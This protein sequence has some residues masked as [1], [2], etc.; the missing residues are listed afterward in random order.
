M[1]LMKIEYS[2]S[3]IN[4]YNQCLLD[5]IGIYI[6]KVIIQTWYILGDFLK[7]CIIMYY[8]ILSHIWFLETLKQKFKNF[9]WRIFQN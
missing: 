4:H 7:N 8:I 5:N 3:F 9:I 6:L 1:N 2:K